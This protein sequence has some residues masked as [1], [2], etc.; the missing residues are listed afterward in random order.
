MLQNTPN[1][2]IDKKSGE[3]VPIPLTIVCSVIHYLLFLYKNVYFYN[4]FYRILVK[5]SPKR[6]KLLPFSWESMLPNPLANTPT[7][8]KKF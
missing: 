5:Y 8:P 1:C 2:T 4:F 6:I 3:Y 7:F